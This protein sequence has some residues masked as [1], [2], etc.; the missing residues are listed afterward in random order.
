MKKYIIYLICVI[1]LISTVLSIKKIPRST[2][3]DNTDTAPPITEVVT[4]TPEQTVLPSLTPDIT[5]SYRQITG[6]EAKEMM[7]TLEDCIILDVR[8]E[9]EYKMGHIPGATLIPVEVITEK[10]PDRLTD[11]NAVILVY[12]RSGNRSKTASQALAEMGYVN[13]YEFG[14]INT[15]EYDITW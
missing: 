10:A 8:T 5:P 4:P 13:V 2:N 9:Q 6:K 12:C 3:P 1:V 7:D 11:K 15:W 14:G